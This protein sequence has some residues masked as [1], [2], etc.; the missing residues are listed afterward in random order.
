MSKFEDVGKWCWWAYLTLCCLYPLAAADD[1]QDGMGKLD[2]QPNRISG[3]VILT[4]GQPAAGA[5]IHVRG[6]AQSGIDARII[7]NEHAK[8]EF[9]VRF[10]S[11]SLSQL[12]LVAA[13]RDSHQTAFHRF[14]WQENQRVTEG[15]KI[16]LE[17]QRTI[18]V[19]VTDQQGAPVE[20]AHVGFQFGWPHIQTGISTDANG[21]AI[22]HLPLSE[23]VQAVVAWKDQVGL[24]YQLYT[25]PRNQV[26]DVK[27]VPPE[28]PQDH[29]ERLVLTGARPL[30]VQFVDADGRPLENVS[31]Y[32]WLLNKDQDNE[33]LNLSYFASSVSEVSDALGETNFAWLPKWQQQIITFWPLAEGY[34]HIRV[35][36]D[37]TSDQQSIRVTL[38][39]LVPI[40]GQVL[41]VAGKPAVDIEIKAT[42][43]GRSH[44]QFRNVARTDADGRYQMD[45]APN[46]IYL[47]TVSSDQWVAAPQTGFAAYPDTP[48]ENR[49]FQL[50]RPTRVHGQLLNE[51][52]QEPIPN[53]RVIVYQYGTG[54]HDLPD[55]D[56]PNPENERYV[57]QPV[58]LY[59]A[60]TDDTGHF[61]FLLGD[62]EFD[63][64]P[65][66]QEKV[67]KFTIAAQPEI[68]MDVTTKIQ[69]EV[70]LLGLVI[71]KESA[72]PIVGAKVYG[73][74]RKFSGRDWQ[75]ETAEDGKFQVRRR[76]E[77]TYV[78][79][80]NG[81]RSLAAIVEVGETKKT[82]IIQLEPVGS[83]HGRLVNEE[84]EPV[85]GQK[86]QYGV[87]VPDTDNSTWSNRFG[88]SVVTDAQG[89]FELMGL[90]QGWEYKVYFPATPEG[91]IPQLTK[92]TIAA[93]E[94]RQLGDL[95]MP[96]LAE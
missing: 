38:Q 37:P 95:T 70:E 82:F 92:F 57:L 71:E 94:D 53:E 24:D 47:L 90:A 58:E 87:D 13:S 88:G 16:Q 10:P 39:R 63:L 68:E 81:D 30:K 17:P 21:Q 4:N 43:R 60:T 8:F 45:L 41:D 48:L 85:A 52:T 35:H 65:P 32:P 79:A 25:L 56:L 42:G 46:Q 34:E 78:H 96:T 9:V 84:G 80:H 23:S 18:A 54:L 11:D 20:N 7:A 31:V 40:S 74:P 28:F 66:Q 6:H 73:V 19:E 12:Q 93:E 64:R 22:A 91:K 49:N 51:R 3:Q 33:S 76:E 36:Y 55:V 26:A 75:A 61:E 27:A 59:Y 83:V 15:F 62:G 44:N 1:L 89:E 50:R 72:R 2:A 5:T 86:L 77:A 67:E 14:A 69:P 29:P